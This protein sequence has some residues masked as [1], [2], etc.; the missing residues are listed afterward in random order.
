MGDLADAFV[1]PRAIL[2]EVL[3][4]AA[5]KYVSADQVAAIYV[6]LGWLERAYQDRD[7]WLATGVLVLPQFDPLRADP[8]FVAFLK[9]MKIEQ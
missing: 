1:A 2:R 8:R 5:R 9:K 7:A 6:G 3:D 4:L